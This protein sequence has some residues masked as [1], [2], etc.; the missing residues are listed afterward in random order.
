MIELVNF[1][2]GKIDVILT[3]QKKEHCLAFVAPA[4]HVAQQVTDVVC[5]EVVLT[6]LQATSC[7]NSSK[8]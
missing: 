3:K 2:L 1:S 4:K 8:K 5:Q 7:L 6:L